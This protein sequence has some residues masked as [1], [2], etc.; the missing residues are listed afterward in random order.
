MSITRLSHILRKGCIVCLLLFIW[1]TAAK[2]ADQSSSIT[3]KVENKTLAEALKQLET[4]A[5]YIFLYNEKSL[6]LNRRVSADLRNVSIEKVLQ[7]ILDPQT[8]Y[9]VTNRQV[10]LYKHRKIEVQAPPQKKASNEISGTI[11]DKNGDPLIG[12]MVMEKGTQNGVISDLDGNY[13]ITIS[14]DGNGILVFSSMGY[15]TEEV[16]IPSRAKFNITMS[17]DA[18]WLDDVVVIGYGTQ[19]KATITGSLAIVDTKEL[20]K[21]P[22]ASITNVLA[23][24][25]P[26]ISTV[27][28]TGQPGADAAQLYIRGAGSLTD[29]NSAPLILVDG[30]ERDFSQID[31]NEI[32]NFSVLKDAA[33]TA[34]FGVRG[35]NGVILITTKRGQE[36]KPSI[37][38]SS[39]TGIQQP[40]SFVQQ[41]GSYEYATFWN[42]KMENDGYSMEANPKLF[43]APEAIDAYRT[44]SDPILYPNTNWGEEMFSKAFLQTKNNINISGGGKNIRYFV[45]LGY[46]FQNGLL[47]QNKTLDYNNNHSYNR[48]NYRANLDFDLTKTT[49]FK[50]GV[51]GNVGKQR[52]PR[53]GGLGAGEQHQWVYAYIWAV[54][55]AGP[56]FVDGKRTKVSTDMLPSGVGNQDGYDAFYGTGYD[57]KHTTTLNIDV[58]LN[59]RLDFITDG[60]SLNIKG[61]YD[62]YFTY[63]KIRPIWTGLEYQKVYAKSYFDNPDLTISDA[64]Y[65]RTPVYVPDTPIHSANMGPYEQPMG[66][67]EQSYGRDRNWYLEAKLHWSRSFGKT[68]AHKVSAMALYNM[69]RDYYTSAGGGT[70]SYIP[71]SYIGYVGRA[72]YSYKDK[73]L[74]DASLGY[75]GSEN[76]APGKTRYGLFPSASIGWVMSKENFMQRQNVISHL[77][78]RASIGKVGNDKTSSR[79]LYMPSSWSA[80]GSYSFGNENPNSLQS[81]GHSTPGNSSVTWETAVKQ[82]YGIDI[83]FFQDRLTAT[84][85]YFTEHRTGILLNRN[86]IPGIIAT[87]L[88]QLNIGIIDNAGY[89]VSLGWNDTTTGGFNYFINSN[90]SFARN[91]IVYMDEVLSQYPWQNQT[92][93]S[94]GLSTGV[95]EFVRIYQESDFIINDE[96]KKVLNPE[97]PQ[98]NVTV[99][100]GDAMYADLSEDGVVDSRDKKV[101]G[102]PTRPEYVLGINGGVSY[103]GFNL[104]MQWSGAANVSRMLGIEYRIP[105]TNAGGRGLLSYFHEDCWSPTNT[106]GTLPR[107][108]EASEG[109]NSEA[110]TL[111]LRDASYLRLKTLTLGY[112]FNSPR[113][114]K[115]G[116]S[117]LAISLS[118]YNLLTFTKLKL[119]DPESMA[120]NFG[121]YPLVKVYTLGLNI[122]F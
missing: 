99:Y 15:K 41:V 118:G 112:T 18:L 45:S 44:G 9:E 33:S 49:T 60:L 40:L 54:P 51:G 28:T 92:G 80:N 73:Y 58:E 103:K 105:F 50:I 63:T 2:A 72:T 16:A 104:S 55:M 14:G 107:A 109:W 117:S 29:E 13:T 37:S 56:G 10:V 1:T 75:N 8:K 89:E 87:S 5:G 20:I 65:D 86:T 67:G 106:D 4:T 110:S 77:K 85:D 95:Y 6:D 84:F 96:G 26:G 30:V 66:Y 11:T 59:Q 69:S 42:Q 32:E 17:E 25:V 101:A 48:Y 122:N 36:G 108:A 38:F 78:F 98:P 114:K 24:S 35:A 31:P 119:M 88:P 22:V 116:I 97:L 21:A 100:P 111:W 70:Y 19:T 12:V 82:N 79:F 93:G 102:Y 64:G 115:A 120:N 74:V 68:G 27:Q 121:A 91:K 71:R 81:Y 43:F 83:N 62:N 34:V 90:L 61:A 57:E 46:L 7:T 52:A 23:G 39:T 53:F 94:T 47:K 3:L 113:L 76:F